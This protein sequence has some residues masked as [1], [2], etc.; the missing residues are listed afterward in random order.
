[1]SKICVNCG[2]ELEESAVF[3][4]ECG[5]KQPDLQPQQQE[6]PSP[7]QKSVSVNQQAPDGAKKPK[8]GL[9]SF[10]LGLIAICTYGILFVPE[11]LGLVFGIIAIKENKRKEWAIAGL[12]M[13][14]VSMFWLVVLLSQV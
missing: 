14:I 4:E 3:C 8:M 9:V 6:I 2:T 12:V 7:V 11:L 10:I 1:M 5:T 13:S